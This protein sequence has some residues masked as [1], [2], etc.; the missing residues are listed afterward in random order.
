MNAMTHPI[1]RRHFLKHTAV[2]LT[3]LSF[4]P[5]HFL[6]LNGATPPSQK[7]N[8]AFVGI[9]GRG[10]TNLQ[11]MDSENVVALCDVD[12]K[13]AAAS[14]GKHPAAK[15]FTDYRKMLDQ[16]H[17]QLD[18]IVVSTPD[19]THAVIAM[20]AMRHGKHVYCEKPLAHSVGEI[21]ALVQA[22]HRYQVITQLGNQGHSFNTIRNFC[23]WIWD[24]AIGR[25]H[26]VHAICG[27]K[28]SQI[29]KL[30]LLAEKHPVPAGLDWDQWLGPAQFRPYNPVYLP[31]SWRAWTPFG[32]GSLGDWTCH[33]VDPVFWAL[34]LGSP[35]AISAKVKDYDLKKHADT[36]PPGVVITYEF[37]ANAKRSPVKLLWFEG[38]EK[39]PR[40]AELEPDD[41]LPKIG[42][43]VMG[44]QGTIIY[45]SHGATSARLIPDAKME[46]Y[47]KPPQTLWRTKAH[48]EDWLNAIRTGKLAGS[49][50]DYGGPLSELAMLGIIAMRLPET[51]LEWD[52]AKAEFK[53]SAEA[54]ALITPRYRK[55]WKL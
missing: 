34:D 7:L 26:T 9:G 30:P 45:G 38:T 24:G 42:A 12:E 3:T 25:V 2:G 51:R 8:L 46:A 15:R 48:H 21:R 32:S 47:K 39:P 16:L 29:D 6:G 53:N 22:A 33:V 20:A 14:F 27:A 1:T 44:D 40:P 55:G 4:V 54:N 49:N 50:F 10:V 5:G 18:G 31:S 52:G 37:P 13:R 19:H 43:V 11:S 35:V 17:K 28:N 36:Y 23:E 41:T